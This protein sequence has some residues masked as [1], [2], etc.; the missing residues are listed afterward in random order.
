MPGRIIFNDSVR[1]TSGEGVLMAEGA[2]INLVD[3]SSLKIMEYM[4]SFVINDAVNLTVPLQVSSH[5]H[6]MALVILALTKVA[7][8]CNNC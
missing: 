2:T 4:D 1:V 7:I 6:S 8:D 3:P 5:R